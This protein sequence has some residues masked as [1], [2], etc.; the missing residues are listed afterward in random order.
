MNFVKNKK[1]AMGVKRLV[2]LDF[3]S[4]GIRAV[5]AEVLDDK[6][7][8]ILS[9]EHKKV[10]GIKNG[11]IGQPSGTAFNV[12]LLLKSLQNSARLRT[13]IQHLSV[14]LGG[15]GM[16]IVT[17]SIERSLRKRTEIT[18]DLIDEM[19]LACENEYSHEG[20]AV[21]DV[22]P[23]RYLVD[24]REMESPE[25][26][27]GSELIGE[28]FL[29]VGDEM[30]KT[31][32]QK[33]MER[34]ASH[35]IDSM[36]L[37]A[38]AF[39]VAVTTATER[40]EGCAVIN[41]G[42]SATTL[43]VYKHEVMQQLIVVPLGG[44]HITRDIEETGISAASAEKLKQ[45]KGVCMQQFIEKPVNIKIAN[46]NPD[47]PPVVLSDAFIALIIEARLDE[48]MQSLFVD[49][50]KRKRNLTHGIVVTGGG[51]RLGKLSD[52]IEERTGIPVRYGDHSGWLTSDCDPKFNGPEYAQII[53]TLILASSNVTDE[54]LSSSL[55]KEVGEAK[56]KS[57]RRSIG[58]TITQGIFRFFEDD[59]NIQSNNKNGAI[60]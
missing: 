9:E 35:K 60:N 57:G 28:Y 27:K 38:E 43:A 55:P 12:G 15:K 24:G 20:L 1:K 2:A 11:I 51:A 4:T 7:I 17:Y 36:L 52:Y 3:A 8:R 48:I 32:L 5:A 44:Q 23:L 42:D 50:D 31:H 45:L 21:Y 46:I 19:A 10:D 47:D 53:G 26:I 25:G 58:E 39:S 6:S 59:S 13:P 30:I 33:C 29:V 37:A 16:R 34:I 40:D 18:A 54:D 49:L 56:K 41:L 22:I 14:A